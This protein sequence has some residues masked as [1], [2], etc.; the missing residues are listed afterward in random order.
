MSRKHLQHLMADDKVDM[1]SMI[2]VTFLLLIYFM[3]TTA[4]I[5]EE[6]DLGI[7]LPSEAAPTA[8]PDNMPSEHIVDILA[9]GQVL[10]NG[11]PMDR[12]DDLSMPQL[13]NTLGRLALADRRI[14]IET[15]VTVQ[16]DPESLHQR[17]IDVLNA[18]SAA[19]IKL[20]SFGAGTG[21]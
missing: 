14:K 10:L 11:A 16:A 3:T 19:G 12:P 9:D 7:T 1:T 20:V 2:D 18:C 6:S 17:S 13:K 21:E 5:K 4:I 15:I 8:N